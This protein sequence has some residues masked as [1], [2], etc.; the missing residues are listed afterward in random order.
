MPD[1][2]YRRYDPVRQSLE[3]RRLPLRRRHL[4]AVRGSRRGHHPAPAA[5]ARP[6]AAPIR[7]DL[8]RG[9][10]AHPTRRPPRRDRDRALDPRRR[11]RRPRRRRRASPSTAAPTSSTS[12]SWT[13]TSCPTSRSVRRWSPRSARRTRLPLDVHL[14]VEDPDRLL[15]DYLDA[16]AAARRGALGGRAP[17]RPAARRDPRRRRARRRG[18]QPGDAGRARWPTSCTPATSCSSCRSIPASPA[19]R[20]CPTC[21]TRRGDSRR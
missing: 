12:T 11:P 20:S 1:L 13:G 16:G 15:D 4:R 19:S 14:M 3:L 18:A 21:S 6:S 9:R 7:R 5:A 2:V 17:S 8:A 10:R